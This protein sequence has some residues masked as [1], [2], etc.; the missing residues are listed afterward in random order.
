MNAISTYRFKMRFCF[1]KRML[2][3]IIVITNMNDIP[4]TDSK[5][6]KRTLK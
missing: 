2:Y 3:N 1:V 5:Q 6:V 4:I